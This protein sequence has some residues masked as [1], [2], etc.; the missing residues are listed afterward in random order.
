MNAPVFFLYC[1]SPLSESQRKRTAQATVNK[2]GGPQAIFIA[3]GLSFYLLLSI[4]RIVFS[5]FEPFAIVA[6]YRKQHTIR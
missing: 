1:T 4:Y 5:L 3:E 2:I 6:E